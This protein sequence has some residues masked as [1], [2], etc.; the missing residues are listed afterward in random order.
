MHQGRIVDRTP[1]SVLAIEQ[2]VR[3]A[4]ERGFRFVVPAEERLV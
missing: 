2:V 4:T 3:V 1:V